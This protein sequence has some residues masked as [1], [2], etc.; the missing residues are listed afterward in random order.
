MSVVHRRGLL[1]VAGYRNRRWDLAKAPKPESVT[2]LREIAR[3][4]YTRIRLEDGSTHRV[5]DRIEVHRAALR[6]R[7]T[8]E[9]G[10]AP[11]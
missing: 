9:A 5:E 6:L 2:R 11:R 10:N 4:G 3:L 1:I 7:P 8:R